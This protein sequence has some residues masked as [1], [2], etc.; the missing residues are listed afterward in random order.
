MT[1]DLITLP[2]SKRSAT[3]WRA[4]VK[5][6][7]KRSCTRPEFCR[8]HGIAMSTLDWWRK[9]LDRGMTPCSSSSN[10][11][12]VMTPLEFLEVTPSRLEAPAWDVELELG[13][14]MVLRLR[15][16]TC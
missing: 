14:G 7:G 8:Q 1:Q 16:S 12:P 13:S 11:P 6:Y 5:A 15:R 4:L 3:E 2:A 9:K 10:S